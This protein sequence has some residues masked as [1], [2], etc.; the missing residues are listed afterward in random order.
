MKVAYSELPTEAKKVV[1][2]LRRLVAKRAAAD[3]NISERRAL[4]AIAKLHDQ[5]YLTMIEKEDGTLA[6]VPSLNDVPLLE[7]QQQ[8]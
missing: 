8:R 2:Y 3:L 6:L 4:H 1:D 5:G 7:E